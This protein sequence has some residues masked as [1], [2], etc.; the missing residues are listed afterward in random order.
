MAPPFP[1]LISSTNTL[2]AAS[3]HP[4]C[5]LISNQSRASEP[6]LHHVDVERSKEEDTEEPLPGAALRRRCIDDH[7][8]PEQTRGGVECGGATAG[9]CAAA[10]TTPMIHPSCCPPR[11][12][13][14]RRKAGADRN[15]ESTPRRPRLHRRPT[16][17]AG[18][19]LSLPTTMR[20]RLM[21]DEPIVVGPRNPL[22]HRPYAG[23]ERRRR[24]D[25]CRSCRGPGFPG[26]RARIH[27]PSGRTQRP[28]LWLELG[29]ATLRRRGP[30][31]P[32]RSVCTATTSR[33]GFSSARACTN[34]ATAHATPRPKAQPLRRSNL[35]ELLCH[36]VR[37]MTP[38]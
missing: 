1:S 9:S 4:C 34:P 8:E 31:T 20:C 33:L 7:V 10:D 19:I 24:S 3:R 13:L 16:V 12:Q 26:A 37:T 2:A 23:A 30:A 28:C 22:S 14:V 21:A 18:R 15:R 25:H 27:A 38:S 11:L 17:S 29:L 6:E 32:E 35:T 5:S 36:D